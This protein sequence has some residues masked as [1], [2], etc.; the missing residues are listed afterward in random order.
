LLLIEFRNKIERGQALH[1]TNDELI[2]WLFVELLAAG[3][4]VDMGVV[5]VDEGAVFGL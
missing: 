5:V 2:S 3:R 4:L 1:W